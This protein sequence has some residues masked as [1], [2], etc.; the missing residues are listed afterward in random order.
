MRGKKKIA[1]ITG[2]TSGFGKIFAEFTDTQF[3]GIDEFWLI[4][5]NQERMEQVCRRMNHRTRPFPYDLSRINKI[6]IGSG[7]GKSV[8][9]NTGK[10]SRIWSNR[11]CK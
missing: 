4:G 6:K 1:I 2:A 5:R 10:C 7:K 11:T 3:R 8:H 9:Q